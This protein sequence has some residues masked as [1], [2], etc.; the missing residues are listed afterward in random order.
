MPLMSKSAYGSIGK[1]LTF[2]RKF[3]TLYVKR[4]SKPTDKRSPAQN[5]QRLR[6]SC[7]KLV[8]AALSSASRFSWRKFLMP[9]AWCWNNPFLHTNLGTGYPCR[10]TPCIPGL[11]YNRRSEWIVGLAKIGI[12]PIGEKTLWL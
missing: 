3:S 1:M 8:W 9:R 10:E 4:Y 5:S 7:T 2:S 6:F 11:P 12:T